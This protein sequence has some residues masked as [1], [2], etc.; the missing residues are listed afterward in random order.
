MNQPTVVQF[1]N[2]VAAEIPPKLEIGTSQVP[3]KFESPM[4]QQ[5]PPQGMVV[6]VIQNVQMDQASVFL[7]IGRFL[8]AAIKATQTPMAP[9]VKVE[10]TAKFEPNEVILISDD[11]NEN[12]DEEKKFAPKA[13]STAKSEDLNSN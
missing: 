4:V 12:E 10:S 9:A 6:P 8:N 3:I 2:Q 13:S 7:A 5:S 1:A 11:E